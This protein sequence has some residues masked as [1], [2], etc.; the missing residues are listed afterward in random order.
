M[1]LEAIVKR[2]ESGRLRGL[3]DE[4]I[5]ALPALYRTA[6]SSLAVAR[7]TSLDNDT[8]DYLESMVQSDWFQ[9]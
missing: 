9:V 1:R 2:M 7:E 4:D 5:L 3:S 6:A 8:M